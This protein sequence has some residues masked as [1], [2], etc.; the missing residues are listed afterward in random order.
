M[1]YFAMDACETFVSEAEEVSL[2]HM[3][4]WAKIRMQPCPFP[5]DSF[6]WTLECLNELLTF[7]PLCCVY[8]LDH[9]GD[10]FIDQWMDPFNAPQLGFT[11]FDCEDCAVLAVRVFYKIRRCIRN[12]D[13]RRVTDLALD[14]DAFVCTVSLITGEEHGYHAVCGLTSSVW[15]EKLVRSLLASKNGTVTCP[16]TKLYFLECTAYTYLH[17]HAPD[18]DDSKLVEEWEAQPLGNLENLVMKCPRSLTSTRHDRLFVIH[19]PQFAHLGCTQITFEQEN[20]EIGVKITQ[21]MNWKGVRAW[22]GSRIHK[23][24][25]D[26][27]MR[28]VDENRALFPL[29]EVAKP[30]FS[31]PN[32]DYVYWSPTKEM[33]SKDRAAVEA[34][35]ATIQTLTVSE[36]DKLYTTLVSCSLFK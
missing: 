19:T 35:G 5:K 15:A 20:G 9:S 29:P 3:Y 16:H 1:C 10:Q 11:G 22:M 27:A 36:K 30:T 28:T 2:A 4:E 7:L 8:R 17:Q 32:A 25:H 24:V 23:E 14:L 33:E 18:V 21:P 26:L 13:M 34:I 6:Y 12:P 31:L